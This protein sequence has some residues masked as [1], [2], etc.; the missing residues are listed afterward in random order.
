MNNKNLLNIINTVTSFLLN[1][2]IT[3]VN[4]SYTNDESIFYKIQTA[5]YQIYLEIYLNDDN[6][7]LE[8]LV[9]IF[10]ISNDKK[11]GYGHTLYTCLVEL[12]KIINERL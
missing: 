1:K 4:V 3:S 11:I 6:T 10:D 8:T 5:N 12:D 2:K 9:N 7:E